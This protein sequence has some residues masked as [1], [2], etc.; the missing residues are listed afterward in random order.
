[1]IAPQEVTN[2]QFKHVFVEGGLHTSIYKFLCKPCTSFV[3][4]TM[5]I[6]PR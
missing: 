3:Y 1:M 5:P 4:T 2:G 6:V